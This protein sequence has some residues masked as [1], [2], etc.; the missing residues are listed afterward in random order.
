MIAHV[1]GS[2]NMKR[3]LFAISGLLLGPLAFSAAPA[4]AETAARNYDCSKPGNA[5]KTVCKNATAAAKPA[6]APK[7]RNYDCS[8]PGNANKAVCRAAAAPATTAAKPARNY[9]C[10][11][12]GNA[13]KTVCKGTAATVPASRPTPPAAAAPTTRAPA[14]RAP[15]TGQ[16]TNPGGPNGAIAKCRDNTYSHSAHRSGTCSRHGGVAQWY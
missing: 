3:I 14:P 4:H 16:S 9:D 10:S 15:V 2:E 13:S 12:P 8:N 11:K 1:Q 6:A 5:N 7:V